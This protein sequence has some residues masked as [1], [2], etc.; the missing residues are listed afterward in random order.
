M[1]FTIIFRRNILEIEQQQIYLNKNIRL[2][3]KLYAKKER[4]SISKMAE[5]LIIEALNKRHVLNINNDE[6]KAGVI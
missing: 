2:Q 4:V 6:K 5:V 1:F 3:L